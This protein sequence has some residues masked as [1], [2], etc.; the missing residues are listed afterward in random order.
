MRSLLIATMFLATAT[1]AFAGGVSGGGGN[2]KPAD[3]VTAQEVK[4]TLQKARM[5]VQFRFNHLSRFSRPEEWSAAERKL[6]ASPKTVMSFVREIPLQLNEQGPCLD[7]EGKE[8]DGSALL[9]P[10]PSICISIPRLTEKLSKD[11]LRVQAFALVLHEFS[12]LVGT[13]EAQA[14]ELQLNGIAA[15]REAEYESTEEQF[16]AARF[17]LAAF[18][19][20]VERYMQP[21]KRDWKRV[22][23]DLR[24]VTQAFSDE[25]LFKTPASRW[26]QLWDTYARARQELTYVRL[27]L[28]GNAACEKSKQSGYVS[29]KQ[30]L[31]GLFAGDRRITYH[32][33]LERSYGPDFP[34]TPFDGEI[35]ERVT[36]PETLAAEMIKVKTEM[37]FYD[38]QLGAI[39]PS[40]IF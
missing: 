12:H 31:D 37:E 4:D 20:M 29:C 39:D 33:Y 35:I 40:E 16:N 36:S 23:G 15:F 26:F 19:Q 27:A 14:D 1:P 32:T 8:M 34:P 18:G 24:E 7:P 17:L 22:A 28:A 2:S 13:D 30:I 9:Q 3:R 11:N 6:F 25:I 38:S 21:V 5:Y 10:S